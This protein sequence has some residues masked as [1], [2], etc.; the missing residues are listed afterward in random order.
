MWQAGN[1]MGTGKS[2]GEVNIP[3][4]ESILWHNMHTRLLIKA[5]VNVREG[6]DKF[7]SIITSMATAYN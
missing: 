6:T 3:A 4:T 7:F 5:F 2:Q 1:I